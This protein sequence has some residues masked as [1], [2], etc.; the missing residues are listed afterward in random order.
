MEGTHS[1]IQS[2]KKK[3]KQQVRGFDSGSQK[4]LDPSRSVS[5]QHTHARHGRCLSSFVD[6]RA[7]STV[8]SAS[9]DH[10]TQLLLQKMVQH[11]TKGEGR[12]EEDGDSST[13]HK[14]TEGKQH[15]LKEEENGN[16]IQKG[17]EEKKHSA[18]FTKRRENSPTFKPVTITEVN[19]KY[20]KMSR[21]PCANL[22]RL[23]CIPHRSCEE[24]SSA[25]RPVGFH[26]PGRYRDITEVNKKITI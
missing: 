22:Q 24:A 26:A 14:N 16:T 13:S 19:K 20:H 17:E 25:S 23:A 5:R 8:E 3:R 4:D 2:L 12:K 7:L 6:S 15:H 9:S 18:I 1:L 21:D 11:Q 10:P